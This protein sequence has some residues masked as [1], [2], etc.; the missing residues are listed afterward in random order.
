MAIVPR[1]FSTTT[2]S[3]SDGSGSSWANRTALF[4]SGNWSSV[5]T[6][7]AFNASD[8]LLCLIEGGLSYTCGQTMASGLFSNPP[9]TTGKALFMH[10]CDSSGNALTPPTIG[11]QSSQLDFST[12][13]LPTIAATTAIRIFDLSTSCVVHARLLNLTSSGHNAAVVNNSSDIVASWDHCKITNSHSG[14]SAGCIL[15][16]HVTNC[17]FEC[18]G[19]S[20]GVIA[21]S[22]APSFANCRIKGNAA[23]TAGTR[24]GFSSTG[25]ML[26]GSVVMGCVTGFTSTTAA[27][28]VTNCT[29]VNCTTGISLGNT[30]RNSRVANTIIANCTTG[31]NLA[32]NGRIQFV[33]NRL[34]NNT[35]N[36]SSF[37]DFPINWGIDTT[38]GTDADEFVDYA[39]RDLRNRANGYTFG[40][41]LGQFDQA[42]TGGGGSTITCT[43]NFS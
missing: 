10:G 39:N 13:T 33:N 12:S 3:G 25:G 42:P 7:F 27:A 2:P 36:L 18:T 29:L 38:F 8:S 28:S 24:A 19:T 5:I 21:N 1:Y 23:A 35:T 15:D 22:A 32:A 30:T 31:V 34:R 40:K 17:I 6:G 37:G 16:G 43:G 20:F 11:W 41:N 26:Q 4:S 9:N 14:T